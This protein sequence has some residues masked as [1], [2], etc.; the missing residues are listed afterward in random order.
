[1]VMV[2]AF[3]ISPGAINLHSNSTAL[4]L[5]PDV[6]DYVEFRLTYPRSAR[7]LTNSIAGRDIHPREYVNNTASLRYFILISLVPTVVVTLV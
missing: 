5:V 2:W 6:T 3:C 7:L 4:L 1:M